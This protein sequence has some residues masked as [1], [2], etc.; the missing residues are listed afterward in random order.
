MDIKELVNQDNK[1]KYQMLGRLISDCQYFLGAGN[2]EEKHLWGKNVR[3]HI[4]VMLAIYDSFS[5][6]ELPDWISYAQIIEYKNWMRCYHKTLTSPWKST[7]WFVK[8]DSLLDYDRDKIKRV[9]DFCRVLR[10]ANDCFEVGFSVR[11]RVEK[12]GYSLNVFV[13]G[14]YG[15]TGRESIGVYTIDSENPADIEELSALGVKFMLTANE[16]VYTFKEDFQWQ[17]YKILYEEI[18]GGGNNAALGW[19][20][21]ERAAVEMA[22]SFRNGH[23]A[24]K[25]VIKVI[26]LKERKEVASY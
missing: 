5:E 12:G 11:P 20:S 23:K 8:I 10:L 22:Q 18:E 2:G 1:F 14:D 21:N 25:G 19:R 24:W 17:G 26:N 13:F 4:A 6:E 16:Y 9:D 7:D 15:E 3:D